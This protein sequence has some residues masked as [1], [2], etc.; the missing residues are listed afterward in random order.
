VNTT[1]LSDE[2]IQACGALRQRD[3]SLILILTHL[4]LFLDA[5]TIHLDPVRNHLPPVEMAYPIY[6]P[7]VFALSTPIFLLLTDL[8]A[9]AGDSVHRLSARLW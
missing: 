8:K 9:D 3:H 6:H 2:D 1:V 5:A 7:I 4:L